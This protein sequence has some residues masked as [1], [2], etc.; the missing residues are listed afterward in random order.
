MRDN[1]ALSCYA[2]LLLSFHGLVDISKAPPRDAAL[3]E[4][5]SSQRRQNDLPF[6]YTT[7]YYYCSTL[8]CE[9][10]KFIYSRYS[11]DHS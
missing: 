8:D 9:I 6:T 10:E 11:L 1:G 7:L 3:L 4:I 2:P 5:S